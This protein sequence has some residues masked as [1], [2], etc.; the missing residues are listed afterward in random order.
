MLF[1]QG[2]RPGLRFLVIF[3][4]K[5]ILYGE[6][7][8]APTPKPQAG[9]P[10]L[11]GCPQLLIQYIRSYPP[12]LEAV[13]SI[14]NLRTHHAV[15]TRDPPNMAHVITHSQYHSTAAHIKSSIRQLSLELSSLLLS[16]A[17]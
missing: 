17:L 14:H 13:S 7:L 6:E 10:P 11:V 5:L 3:S 12:Y 16:T 15:V 9:W 8:L 1:I 4:N 2:I